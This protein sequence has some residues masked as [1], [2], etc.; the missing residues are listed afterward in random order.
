MD[1][2]AGNI[3]HQLALGF[4]VMFQ[5]QNIFFCF[6]GAFL[7]TL[8]GVLPGLG[9]V[10]AMS[11]LLPITF[12]VSPVSALIMLSGIYYGAMYGGS[13]TSILVN[14]P[15]EVASVVTCLDGYQMARQGRAG[16]A[17]GIAAFGSFIAGTFGIVLLMFLAPTLA[18]FALRFGPPEYFSL[19][20]LGLAIVTYLASGSMLKALMMVAVGLFLGTIGT[21]IVSGRDRFTFG[22]PVLENGVGLVPLVMG[23]FGL[24]EIFSN[25]DHKATTRTIALDRVKNILPSL[26]D[27]KKS[28]WPM[29]RGSFMGFF[30]GVLP[31]GGAI[32]AAF[33]SYAVEKRISKT[34]ERFGKGAIEGVAGPESANN[35]G[36][37]GA[38]VPMLALGIPSNVTIALLLGA[39]MVHGIEPGPLLSTQHPEI[40]W[41]LIA[42]MYFGNLILLVLNLPLIWVWIKLL[43]VPYRILFPIIT[44]FC[45]AGVYTSSYQIADIVLMLFFGVVGWGLK[46]LEFEGAPLVLAFV[47]GPMLEKSLRQSLILS[48]GDF[49]IFF[50]RPISAILML[51]V[52]FVLFS[53]LIPRLGRKPLPR[54]D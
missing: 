20:M 34:P 5:P 12:H 8:V 21:D 36:S 47:L 7:G 31:G 13:T 42:S 17:L 10:G 38:F 50:V 28:A 11:I 2:L 32:L 19:M 49:G 46:K 9:P 3:L 22:I 30:L 41:G 16:P 45:I 26:D 25:I 6:L 52:V 43:K 35:A 4:A 39:L 1:A 18:N 14:I 48:D 33:A 15:G 54:E 24:G 40:F 51:L 53:P 37:T 23:L 27:W 29:V 44:L